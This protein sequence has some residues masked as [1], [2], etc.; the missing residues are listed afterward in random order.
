MEQG[1]LELMFQ[2]FVKFMKQDDRPYTVQ[3]IEQTHSER[4]EPLK[5][6]RPTPSIL[7]RRGSFYSSNND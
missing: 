2:K 7:S 3:P 4:K 5:L 6:T 1:Q